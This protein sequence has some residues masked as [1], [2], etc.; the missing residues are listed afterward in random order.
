MRNALPSGS[1]SPSLASCL[2]FVL[3]VTA[4]AACSSSSGGS[5][6]GSVNGTV[7]GI[8]FSAASGLAEVGPESTSTDC[9]GSSDGGTSSCTTTSSGQVVAVILT[10][11]AGI[12]CETVTGQG[13]KFANLDALEL[14]V[15]TAGG[16]VATG[17]YTLVGAE[18]GLSSGAEAILLTTSA[19]CGQSL[20]LTAS[21]GTITLSAITAT[22]V[23][24]SFNVTFGS[25]G[26]FSG[27]FDE[28]LCE[29]PDGGGMMSA[30]D[31]GTCQQ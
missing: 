10:N 20:D 9:T 6:N 5:G 11:R 18:S 27:S 1:P 30:G 2:P 7:D 14:A 19:N 26:S 4:L 8:S 29:L 21:S 16:T 25:M 17:T 28:P 31:A 23:S 12:S 24:G 3:A 13:N 22:S 15:G